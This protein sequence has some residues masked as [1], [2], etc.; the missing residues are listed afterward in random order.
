M[1][2][3]GI[4]PGTTA[5][6]CAIVEAAVPPRLLHSQLLNIHSRDPT[7]RLCQIH[8]GMDA[9]IKQWRPQVASVEKI[10]FAANTKTAIAV[11]QARGVILLTAGLR[12]I[13][14][15]EYTPREIKKALTGDGAA[16]KT[17]IK[18]MV[19]L[20][21][22]EAACLAARD[23]VFD[24]IASAL[25]CCFHEKLHLKRSTDLQHIISII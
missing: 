2:I 12:G 18:K 8:T 23:D 21:V 9:L 4:D 10:F 25:A 20:T 3:L 22:P 7:E 6:G 14:V 1:I 19:Q 24:A 16:D 11:A 17:Q 13:S 15:S 5:I